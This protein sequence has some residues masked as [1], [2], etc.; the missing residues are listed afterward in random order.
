LERR[1]DLRFSSFPLR[2]SNLC[3][4]NHEPLILHYRDRN[5][6]EV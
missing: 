3:G 6:A 4:A 1:R 5:A 2:R